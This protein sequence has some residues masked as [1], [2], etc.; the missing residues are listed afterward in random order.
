MRE[1]KAHEPVVGLEDGCVDGKVCGGAGEELDVDAPLR[2]VEV[3]GLERAL[4]A[5]ELVLVRVLVAAVV[6]RPGV[7]LG[8]LVCEAGGERV[9]H[10]L[11]ADV[12]RRD[13]LQP[14]PLPV[15]LLRED[16][17]ELGVNL[18]ERPGPLI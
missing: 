11:R 6:A 1:V 8:V 15:L 14:V 7:P 9:A 10:G 18:L 5:Q 17:R 16:A 2:G 13:H 4:L 12:L 3:E